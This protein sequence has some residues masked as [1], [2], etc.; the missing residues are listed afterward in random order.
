M[1]ETPQ[2]QGD[3]MLPREMIIERTRDYVAEHFLYMR[4]D[5]VIE[6]SD[7]LLERGIIDSMGVVE[8][9]A[10][11][12]DTF[13]VAVADEEITEANFGSLDGI[14]RFVMRKRAAAVS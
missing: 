14:A 4:P 1:L 3:E 2:M 7:S 12:E 11:V 13:A 5:A 8:L 10:F 6:P 9:L